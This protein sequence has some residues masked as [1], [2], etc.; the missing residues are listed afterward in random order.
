MSGLN[1]ELF[2][3]SPPETKL[4]RIG[5]TSLLKKYLKVEKTCVVVET[6]IYFNSIKEQREHFT[7]DHATYTT[8]LVNFIHLLILNYF[9][10]H[11]DQEEAELTPQTVSGMEL[12]D[13]VGSFINHNISPSSVRNNKL[14]FIDL[15]LQ[16]DNIYFEY[17][18]DPTTIMR[19]AIEIEESC[20]SS[21]N[22]TSETYN[23]IEIMAKR[24]DTIYG[25][26]Y[27]SICGKV[28]M[29]LDYESLECLEYGTHNIKKLFTGEVEPA[30]YGFLTAN[31]MFPAAFK[32]ER[33]MLELRKMQNIVAKTS[34]M[35]PC[36]R[37]KARNCEYTPA[38]RRSIDEP[39]GVDCKCLSC[40][41]KF[42]MV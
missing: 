38:Q 1:P 18:H 27:N 10:K 26:I 30:Q 9:D 31:D 3:N 29:C 33:D 4:L 35:F 32:K 6:L 22:K 15:I 13:L 41:I 2:L 39:T 21:A 34:T 24:W 40:G 12:L 11:P 25:D 17:Y 14:F 28:T 37:C 5:T 20:Y 19:Y 23:S 8:N 16:R 7:I 42:H 36:P